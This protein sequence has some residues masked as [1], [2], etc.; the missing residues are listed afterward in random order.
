MVQ[1]EKTRKP[2][3]SPENFEVEIEEKDGKFIARLQR[4]GSAVQ[5][6]HIAATREEAQSWIDERIQT[7]TR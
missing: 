7:L 2:A 3:F 6:C 5:R 1:N 4:I